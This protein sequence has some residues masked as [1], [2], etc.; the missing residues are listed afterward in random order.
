MATIDRGKSGEIIGY[1]RARRCAHVLTGAM[2]SLTIAVCAYA[3]VPAPLVLESKIPLGNVR[4][5]IDH[6]AID[7]A[8]RILYVAEL[9]NDSVGVVNLTTGRLVRRVTGFREPQG[10]A[11][12]AATDTVCVASG[13]DGSV[14]LFQGPG[15][16]LAGRIGL[17][18]DADN[19]RVEPKSTRVWAGYGS[20]ALAVIDTLSRQR[21]ASVALKGHP[22][23]LQFDESRRRVLVNVPDTREIAVVDMDK[24]EQ[25]AS[26]PLHGLGANFPMAIDAAREQVLVAFRSP[27]RLGIFGLSTGER[28]S[29]IATCRDAD[30]VFVDPQRS[31]VYL[32]C[33]EGFIDVLAA[34]PNGYV[35]VGQVATAIGARTALFVPELDRLFVAVRSSGAEPAA[36]W[37][38]RPGP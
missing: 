9:G 7:L 30:D 35:G 27:P 16:T 13:G 33:G 25:I 12:V 1:R 14:Q 29:V 22:E 10:I 24:D 23:S 11:Y 6:L 38:F 20:G 17:G 2:L 8:R 5:R 19:V 36:I 34:T 37:V 28:G 15:L 3:A 21:I 4:G 18:D 31:R 26:W 32:S